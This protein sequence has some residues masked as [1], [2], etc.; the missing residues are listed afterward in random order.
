MSLV[1]PDGRAHSLMK[2][3]SKRLQ[4]CIGMEPFQTMVFNSRLVR[5]VACQRTSEA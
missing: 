5:E 1:V 2:E 3:L 4:P